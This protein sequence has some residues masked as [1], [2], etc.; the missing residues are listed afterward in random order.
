LRALLKRTGSWLFI[1]LALVVSALVTSWSMIGYASS[2]PAGTLATGLFSLL[3][4]AI[5]LLLSALHI[6]LK[7]V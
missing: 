1:H 3:L 4:V 6:L 7:L 2:G 5:V